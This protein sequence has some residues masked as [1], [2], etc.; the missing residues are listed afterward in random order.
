MNHSEIF[1]GIPSGIEIILGKKTFTQ[2][3]AFTG[4]GP[5]REQI[6][7]VYNSTNYSSFLTTS[8][9]ILQ[10]NQNG[11]STQGTLNIGS[12]SQLAGTSTELAVTAGAFVLSNTPFHMSFSGFVSNM[13]ISQGT[14]GFLG[15]TETGVLIGGATATSY[16]C[17]IGNGNVNSQVIS[18]NNSY[19]TLIVSGGISGFTTSG[20]GTHPLACSLAIKPLTITAGTAIVT[21]SATVYIES[22]ITGAT[23]NY[24]LWI[25]SGKTRFDD[26]IAAPATN[27]GV[28]IVNYYGSAA[29]NFLGDPN[30]WLRINVNG[31]D[32]KCPLYT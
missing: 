17:Q 3:V 8:A 23:N 20:S 14:G 18:L 26:N 7:F 19:A 24:S 31:T 1:F 2:I 27:I 10:L 25:D 21:N 30:L 6:R 11:V 15:R 32:Y 28:G 5:A 9:G 22:A 13:S 4:G 16:R 12:S 29:T